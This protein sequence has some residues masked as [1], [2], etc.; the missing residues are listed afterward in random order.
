[1]GSDLTYFS[2]LGISEDASQ[3]ELEA[4]YRELAEYLT[5]PTVPAHLREWAGRQAAL[6]DEAY[7]VLAD[8]E[9]RAAVRRNREGAAVETATI[10]VPAATQASTAAQVEPGEEARPAARRRTKAGAGGG[11]KVA[12]EGPDARGSA[13]STRLLRLRSQPLVLGAVIGLAA[14]G[15]VVLFRVGLPGNGGAE[16]APPADQAGELVP[17]DK[18][19]IAQLTAAVKEDPKNTEALFELGES[20]FLAGE[21]Q[22]AIDWFSK[23][24]AI[25]PDNV[26]A[27]TDIG[28]SNYNL[29]FTEE[30][31]A[32]WLAALAIDPNDVQVHYNLGFLYAN[33]EP[34]D[35]AAAMSEWQTVLELAP[36][37]NLAK[38]VQ[39]HLEGLSEQSTPEASPAAP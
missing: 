21:W 31:K 28:T 7:A 12:A 37:S 8:P 11:L 15:A 10:A 17:L 3:E 25:E 26:H 4:R 2:L 6:V 22:S 24:V 27:L 38:T 19:R 5:S 29:G 23:L 20:Y 14:L 34:Q 39:V 33:A 36:D 18:E 30:A 1:M 13:L 35:L 32:T 16:E 9:Q